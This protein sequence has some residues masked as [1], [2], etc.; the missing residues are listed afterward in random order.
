[1]GR[2]RAHLGVH[3]GG[4]L[5]DVLCIGAAQVVDLVVDIDA[6]SFRNGSGGGIFG[7]I[8]RRRLAVQNSFILH[9]V[10]LRHARLLS[11]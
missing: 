8:A 2:N 1:M 9:P 6:D 3:H 7:V 4:E 10:P 5:P 11:R